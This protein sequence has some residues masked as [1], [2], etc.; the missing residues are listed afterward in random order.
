MGFLAEE[1]AHRDLSR[2]NPALWDTMLKRAMIAGCT[3]ASFTVED[4][5]L[6]RLKRLESRE[7]VE[8]GGQ[9][10]QMINVG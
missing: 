6:E 1:G 7:L 2:D 9:L 8:R 4:F 5:S 10:L 3:M